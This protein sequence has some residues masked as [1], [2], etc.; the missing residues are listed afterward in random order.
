MQLAG[1][2]HYENTPIQYTETLRTGKM[3]KKSLEKNQYSFVLFKT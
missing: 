1:D 2:A 3:E